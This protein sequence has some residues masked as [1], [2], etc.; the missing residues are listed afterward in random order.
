MAAKATIP[1]TSSLGVTLGSGRGRIA[2]FPEPDHREFSGDPYADGVPVPTCPDRYYSEDYVVRPL[3][4]CHAVS[5]AAGSTSPP[6]YRI[7]PATFIQ[8]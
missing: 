4:N 7:N 5:A 8:P 2:I 6:A 1:E 3:L